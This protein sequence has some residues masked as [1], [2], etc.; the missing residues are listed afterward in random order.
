[1]RHKTV[2]AAL[3]ALIIAPLV[4][5]GPAQTPKP[6]TRSL[7]LADCI[8]K[9]LEGNLD[10]A[11][12][13]L[14]PEMDS[15]SAAVAREKF[16]PEFGL[17]SNYLD[18]DIPSSWG[19]EGPTIKTKMD[20]YQLGVTQ[21]TPLGTELDLSLSTRKTDTSRAYTT[22]NPA[23]FSE[24]R[25]N[26]RQPLLRDFGFR[27]NRYESIK[28]RRQLDM[29]EAALK[30][31]LLKTV[32]GVEEA[33]WNLYYARES[34]RVLEMSLAQSRET[35]KRNEDATR[36]GTKSAVEVLSAETEVAG[37][38]DRV[39]SARL[40]VEKTENRLKSLLNMPVA[41]AAA[42]AQPAPEEAPLTIVPTDEPRAEKR[43]VTY[44]DARATALAE[45]PELARTDAMMANAATDIGYF[46]NQLL[47][48]L[49]LNFSLW[50]P[51][52]SGI[53]YIFQDNNPL[54]GIVIDT[55]YGSRGQSFRD[56]WKMAYNNLSFNFT[57]TLPLS[58][59]VSR[60][61]LARA[62]LAQDQARLQLEKERQTIDVEVMEAVKDLEASATKIETSARYRGLMEKRVQAETQRYDLGLVGSEWLF[63]YQ[64]NLAQAKSDEIRAVIDYK[65][66]LAALDKAMGTTIR[67]KGLKF[68]EYEF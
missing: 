35:L 7:S 16:L 34:L 36:I 50:S 3:A 56:V 22:V 26:L 17:S 42:G 53:K 68:K 18:Q 63:T 28:A 20:Y 24:F 12:E 62:R 32:Y 58:N 10:L 29:S 30:S 21:R 55:I 46:R 23:Y 67:A 39:L 15:A 14:N 44:E 27:A 52:Q 48:R 61:G 60:A 38:E 64:R 8:R 51:G 65:I 49:D 6:A 19:V 66:A 13:A 43:A 5:S 2:L 47:P 11:I 25:L 31:T 45:R 57:L 33:Y 9:A 59:F 41:G 1:M 54:T 40:Q 4:W 37:Y